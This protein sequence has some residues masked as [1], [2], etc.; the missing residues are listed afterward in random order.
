MVSKYKYNFQNSG[1]MESMLAKCVLKC[2]NLIRT[3]KEKNCSLHYFI[4]SSIPSPM[5][6]VSQF[7]CVHLEEVNLSVFKF[8]HIV[9]VNFALIGCGLSTRFLGFSDELI[10]SDVYCNSS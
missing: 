8:Q 6:L 10:L 9:E 4:G 7:K 2:I 5:N 1:A 3:K